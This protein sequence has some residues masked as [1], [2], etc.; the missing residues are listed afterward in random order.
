MHLT[1]GFAALLADLQAAL[2]RA[3]PQRPWGTARSG[4]T[5]LQVVRDLAFGIV[6]AK[7]VKVEPRTE[8]VMNKRKALFVTV[9][10]KPVTP[11][12]L[13]SYAALGVLATTASLLDSMGAESD[14]GST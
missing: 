9:L 12:A 4:P 2:L 13:S 5:L 14:T 7:N 3:A 1:A 6:L 11:A 8:L 10:H